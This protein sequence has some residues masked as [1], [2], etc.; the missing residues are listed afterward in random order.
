MIYGGNLMSNFEGSVLSQD[1]SMTK[2]ILLSEIYKILDKKPSVLIDALN[3]SGIKTSNSI[4]KE[5][6][7]DKVVD[8]LYD[9]EKFR[10][11]LA[12]V[13]SNGYSNA[14]GNFLGKVKGAFSKTTS[15]TD[16]DTDS[17]SVNVGAS[18]I[19]AIAGA[20][21]SVFSFGASIKQGK[22]QKEAD[23]QQLRMAL[24]GGESKKTNWLP[25]VIIGGV[26]L[27]G[28]IVAFVSLRKK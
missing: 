19:G 5:S 23:K 12:K 15:D 22:N 7:V 28:G 18:P 20:I 14:D 26:L 24:L 1:K 9:S 11:N 27:I 6:L 21:G 25:I 13:I 2:D 16:T 4:S 3:E 10:S 17:P 8:A